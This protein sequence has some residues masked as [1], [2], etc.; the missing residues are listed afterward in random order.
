MITIKIHYLLSF[1]FL[2]LFFKLYIILIL[3]KNTLKLFV[4]YKKIQYVFCFNYFNSFLI[5][6]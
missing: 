4:S 5:I 1:L 6:Y 3:D 2:G